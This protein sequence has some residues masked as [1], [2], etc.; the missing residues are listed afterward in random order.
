MKMHVD[1]LP[2]HTETLFKNE[3]DR[4]RPGTVV[5]WTTDHV[6]QGWV[7]V[8]LQH[9]DITHRQNHSTTQNKPHR[10]K[11]KRRRDDEREERM[12]EERTRR[13]R[14]RQERREGKE[15]ERRKRK[16]KYGDKGEN[17]LQLQPGFFGELISS[18][19]YSRASA[20][21]LILDYSYRRALSR[22][23]IIIARMVQRRPSMEAL[24]VV[25]QTRILEA[26]KIRD[27]EDRATISKA[28]KEIRD[29]LKASGNGGGSS[30]GPTRRR[31]K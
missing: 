18:Y 12:I 16:K 8:G 28:A 20:G 9:N 31:K 25:K 14:E 5:V 17:R 23:V 29:A 27:E 11:E 19:S 24:H 2:V 21:E 13:E 26:V 1:V 7:V 3:G 4:R 15:N 30:S 22:I 6:D 10:S